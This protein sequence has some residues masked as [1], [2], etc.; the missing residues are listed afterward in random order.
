VFQDFREAV[1]Y[2]FES[3]VASKPHR[4]VG[5][6]RDTRQPWHTRQ[7]LD[8]MGA[9]DMRMRNIKVTGSKGKGSTAR[10]IAGLLQTRGLRVGLFTSPHMIDYT[11]RIRVSGV[12]IEEQDFMRLLSACA[13]DIDA[14]RQ[15]FE[16]H[17]YFGPVGL[18]AVVA[19]LY[20]AEQGTDVNVF[21]LGRGARYDDV[22]AVWGELAVVTPIHMEHAEQLGP[23]LED[24]ASS[25]AGVITSGV[26]HVVVGEQTPGAL[27]VLRQEAE[28][29]GVDMDVY[30]DA[31]GVSDVEVG[32][33]GT[34][35]TVRTP[36]ARYRHLCISLLG[37][38]QADNLATAL[39]VVERFCGTLENVP[40]LRAY[41]ARLSFPGRCQLLAG[42]PA[43]L[44]DACINR[45][46]AAHVREV[47]AQLG[48][49]PV[50]AVVGVP[51]DKDY[52]GVFEALAPVCSSYVVT[53]ARNPHL[54]FALD[55]AA[56]ASVWQPT[57]ACESLEQ[58]LCIATKRA[59][60]DG[61]V[62]V[63][64]TQSLIG[65]ALAYYRVPTRHQDEFAGATSV[66][67]GHAVPTL[68]S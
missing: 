38:H 60:E 7:L 48:R 36:Q 62:L 55:A 22:N 64:G 47:I 49:Q 19:S 43:V 57:S 67:L 52:D 33:T 59:G 15:N 26:R 8:R 5:L 41:L 27:A 35:M 53:T 40:E 68:E 58:A 13:P 12:A 11:E 16:P 2:M 63:A 14:M 17:E 50:V 24:I 54:R 46:G 56:R 61:L 4:P 1:K 30:G 31:Y 42:R 51:S 6:D 20:F 39:T 37:R 34:C 25:K 44:I 29:R 65:E 3:Y 9:P 45:E 32:G 23:E 28:R 66:G 18:I 10:L 21:E